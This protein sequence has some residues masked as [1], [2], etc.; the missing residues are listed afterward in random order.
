MAKVHMEF[1]ENTI[2]KVFK[3]ASEKWFKKAGAYIRKVAMNSIKKKKDPAKHAPVGKPPFYHGATFGGGTNFK[4]SV[5]YKASKEDVVVG[6]IA[7]RLGALGALHEHGGSNTVKYIASER[8]NHVFKIG[9]RGP[10]S[11]KKFDS[12]KGRR[13]AGYFDPLTGY[14]VIDTELRTKRMADHATRVNRRVL[15]E[16]FTK[17]K[18]ASYPARPFMRP[19]YKTSEPYLLKMW[20]NAIN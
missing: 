10:V 15:K 13:I 1:Y 20:K 4:Q 6:P 5:M 17:T 9:E 3:D 16:Y 19:A 7:G 8:Y 14:P 12:A 18:T 2:S 11:T